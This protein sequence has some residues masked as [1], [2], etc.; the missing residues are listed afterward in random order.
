VRNIINRYRVLLLVIIAAFAVLS[1]NQFS[2][3]HINPSFNDYIP[4]G[5]GN[6]AYLKKLDSIF[7]GSEK[8]LL[9]LE[10]EQG[11]LNSNTYNRITNLTTDLQYLNGI[12]RCMSLADVIEIKLEDGMTSFEPIIDTFPEEKEELDALK[13]RILNNEMGQRFISK[14]LTATAIIL[15]K[16]SNIADNVIIPEIKAVIDNNNGAD[17]IYIGGLAYVRQSIKSYIKHDLITLLPGALILML[18]MLYFS[19]RE[20]KGV[21]LPFAVVILSI[22]FSFG[23][24]AIIGWEISLIS[25]LLPIMLIAIANDYSIH[26]INLYQEK[27]ES[28]TGKSMKEISIEIYQELRNPIFIT[29]LTT[30]GGILGL[31]S[32]KMPPAAQ[33]GVLTATGIG[34]AL[35]MSLFLVPV[36]LSFYPLPKERRLKKV[37]KKFFMTHVLELF[38][39]WINNY[40]KRVVITFVA[41]SLA[42]S[43]GL[44]YLKVDTNV[45]NYFIG[46]SDIK[47]GIDLVNK[48]FGGSQY[49]SVLFSGEVLSPETLTRLDQYT[50]EIK[51]IHQVGHVISPSSFFKELS[52]GMYLPGEAGYQTL[53]KTEDEALQYME[54]VSMSGFDESISQLID[55]NYENARILVS[56]RDGS[57]QTM[58]TILKALKDITAKDPNLVCIAGPGLSKI[59]I[60]DMVI[61]GQIKSLIMAL[62]IIFVLL[63]LIFKSLMAGIK[64]SL[65][66]VLST[67]FLFG[68]M[69]FLNIPLDIVTAL[70][71]SIMIGVGVDYTIHFLWRY[72]MEYK[73]F[74]DANQAIAN[75]LKTA[76]RGIVFNAFS[77]IVGFSILIFS[78]FAPLR[79]FGLLVVVSIFSCLI[80]AL[81]LIPAIIKITKPKFLES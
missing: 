21:I 33:L 24:M 59:Q 41:V 76:G 77:V 45:E 52:K 80:S 32:H 60:A 44:F 64:G 57:N 70:L 3:L 16:A 5:V 71:S 14:D 72:K 54:L 46:Q 69:G 23:L 73:A 7:G 50:K 40:P 19:F 17:R 31:L 58:K 55:Y 42:S 4:D 13:S 34:L 8:L 9:I 75:T 68:L 79:F 22:A 43:L 11:I 81:L 53:P 35:F 61:Q 67:V 18:L 10:N 6:R 62:L 65:P 15:T 37:Q 47:K 27:C 78:S 36:L 39:N 56:M 66:L 12:E 26:L 29:A 28:E 48:K 38:A 2:K 51:E 1:S 30:I 25:I 74:G 63:S 20:W 49:V